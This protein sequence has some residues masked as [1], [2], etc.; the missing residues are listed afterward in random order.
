MTTRACSGLLL[1]VVAASGFDEPSDERDQ[2]D[3]T[4][5]YMYLSKHEEA[6][7][8]LGGHKTI[9]FQVDDKY[10]GGEKFKCA[11]KRVAEVPTEANY[12]LV[13]YTVAQNWC[14]KRYKADMKAAKYDG[15]A[16]CIVDT[17]NRVA[18]GTYHRF[19]KISSDN[20]TLFYGLENSQFVQARILMMAHNGDYELQKCRTFCNDLFD[21]PIAQG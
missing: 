19:M 21:K 11:L 18:N 13:N 8:K 6:F 1:L 12:G 7:V 17:Y 15:Y 20:R 10:P 2:P 9:P 14:Y 5:P 16:G 3:Y 4:E